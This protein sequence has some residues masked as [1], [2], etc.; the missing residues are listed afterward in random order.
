MIDLYRFYDTNQR[1]LYIGI[2]LNAATRA[3]QH[4]TEKP[5]WTDVAHMRIEHLDVT[6]RAEAL[7][8]ER[9]AIQTERP[10]HNI[11]HNTSPQEQL[12]METPPNPNDGLIGWY[13]LTPTDATP[14]GHQGYVV[15][16]LEGGYHLIQWFSWVHGGPTNCG[17]YHLSDMAGWAFYDDHDDFTTAADART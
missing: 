16:R 14:P 9:R 3:A 17:V 11:V 10:L 13:V 8:I 7:D 12:A 1:L 5:W 4:R 6:S 15:D 2:S